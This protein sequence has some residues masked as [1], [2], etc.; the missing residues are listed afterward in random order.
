MYVFLLLLLRIKVC[1][2]VV[3]KYTYVYAAYDVLWWHNVVWYS[4]VNIV[5]Y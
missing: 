2:L 4:Y 5:N 1:V 3:R